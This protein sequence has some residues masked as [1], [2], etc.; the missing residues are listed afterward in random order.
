MSEINKKLK[1]ILFNVFND[2]EFVA[3]I[4]AQLK[5]DELKKT[6]IDYIT[7]RPQIT[8]EEITLVAIEMKRNY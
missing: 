2:D 3:C 7:Q 5:T 6:M 1:K 8:S 4:L